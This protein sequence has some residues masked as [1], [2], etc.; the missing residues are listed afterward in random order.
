MRP[1]AARMSEMPGPKVYNLW[2][3][4]S[5]TMRQ[6]GIIQYSLAPNRQ[7][8]AKNLIRN[9]LFNGFRRLS[10]QAV[11]WVIPFGLGYGTY[12]W[13]KSYDAWQNSKAAHVAGHGAD[14]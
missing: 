12:T 8:P 1:T 2:W 5:G 4:D 13:A 3:G 10:S 6:K 14:H 9:Y 11:Y 7:R